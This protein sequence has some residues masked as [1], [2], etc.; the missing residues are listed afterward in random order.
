[1]KLEPYWLDTAPP[2]T[3]GE[4]GP[5]E[6]TADVAII[7]GGFTGLSAAL[8]AVRKGASVVVLEAEAIGSKASVR[9]GG[10]VNNG[11]AHSFVAVAAKHGVDRARELYQAFDAAVDAVERIVREE[12]IYCDFRRAG[13][14]KLAAKPAHFA[15]IAK[16][17]EMISREVD[18]DT[19]LLFKDDIPNEVGTDR[20]FGGM[21]HMGKFSRGLASA[22]ARSGAR[23]F[24]NACVTKLEKQAGSGFR[25]TTPRGHLTASQ[26]LVATGGNTEG[27]F[28]YFRR[29]F[30]PIGAF[31]IATEPLDPAVAA[32]SMPG[33][34]TVTTSRNLV[35]LFRL[36]PDNRLIYGGRARFALSSPRSDA[37]SGVILQRSMLDVFPQLTGVSIDYCWGGLIDMTADRFPRTGERDG[38]YFAMGY[39]GYGAQMSVHLGSLMVDVMDGH[40]EKSPFGHMPWPAIPGHFGR[41]W[42]L[43]IVGAYYKFK[44]LVS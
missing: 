20:F 43:P 4:Q 42:F 13:K 15:S 8:A 21:L 22:A 34:R 2:F 18:P 9:N 25:I 40:P 37:K 1:M 33:N 3:D 7:G 6:G 32:R 23:I 27:P 28:G 36:S 10:H 35:N 29:R 19:Q 30:V 14:V 31:V 11:M 5:L 39:S 26:V 17:Y 38:L 16:N 24:E 12:K 41:P 44:D